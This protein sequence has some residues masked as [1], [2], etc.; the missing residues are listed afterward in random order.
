VK[1]TDRIIPGGNEKILFVDD[2]VA[3]ARLGKKILE[4]LGYHVSMMTDSPEAFKLFYS[5]P[6]SFD[7]VITDMTMPGLTGTKLTRKIRNIRPDTPVILCTGY[8]EIINEEKALNMGI[9]AFIMKPL[10]TQELAVK[11]RE[12]LDS[13]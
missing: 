9:N 3:L 6:E 2:E 4:N 11:V 8:S 1:E 12:V 10:V 7:L 5:D 13:E